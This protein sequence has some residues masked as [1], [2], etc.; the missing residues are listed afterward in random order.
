MDWLTPAKKICT[1]GKKYR[2]AVLILLLGILLM[3]IPGKKSDREALPESQPEAPAGMTVSEEL[4]AIL[5]RI[6]GVGKAEVMLTV[7]TGEET[8]YQ[9][10]TNGELELTTVTVTDAQRNETGLIRKVNPPVYLGA[11]V[12]CQ[13]AD[14]PAVCLQVIEAVSRVTGLRTDRISVLKMN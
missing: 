4:S 8:V 10:D 1:Y 6:D 11:I 13:G 14:N 7:A 2:Y 5:S 3:L 12:V 9:S